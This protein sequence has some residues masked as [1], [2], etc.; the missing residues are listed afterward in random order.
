MCKHRPSNPKTHLQT[1]YKL[2]V[3]AQLSRKRQ[4]IPQTATTGAVPAAQRKMPMFRHMAMGST[5]AQ[6]TL[7]DAYFL[8][9]LLT[10]RQISPEIEALG[11]AA[12]APIWC[13]KMQI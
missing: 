9:V 13:V 7:P 2:A 12:A 1:G 10:S 6:G 11:S 3:T 4:Q 5:S 8:S